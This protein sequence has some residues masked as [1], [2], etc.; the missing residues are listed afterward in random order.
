[1]SCT[2]FFSSS[3][4][5]QPKTSFGRPECTAAFFIK[6]GHSINLVKTA[7]RVYSFMDES[8]D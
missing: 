8:D 3:N 1:M 5:C 6:K 2:Y 7:E 4:Y